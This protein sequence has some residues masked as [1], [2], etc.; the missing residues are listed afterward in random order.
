MFVEKHARPIVTYYVFESILQIR[1]QICPSHNLLS[2]VS[3][4][5]RRK[6]KLYLKMLITNNKQLR[7]NIPFHDI[8]AFF[9]FILPDVFV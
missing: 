3:L 4:V 9:V 6:A 2:P 8:I 1:H 7:Q 5:Q